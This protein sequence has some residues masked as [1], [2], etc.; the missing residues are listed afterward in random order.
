MANPFFEAIMGN[1]SRG[2]IPS[3]EVL[4]QMAQ[5]F[6][7]N[8]LGFLLQKKLNIPSNLVGNPDAML[9]YLLQSGQVQQ[10]QVDWAKQQMAQQGFK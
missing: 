6:K 9:G 4:V 10:S 7:R 2:S 8:P 3:K 1:N 5:Q